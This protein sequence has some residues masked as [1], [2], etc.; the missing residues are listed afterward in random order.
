[1]R[2]RG[3]NIHM[4]RFVLVL[5]ALALVVPQTAVQ[6][7][8][9]RRIRSW[10]E[11]RGSHSAYIDV[12]LEQ[13]VRISCCRS[14]V[15]KKGTRIVFPDIN[16]QTRG[17]FAGFLIERLSDGKFIVGGMRI[18]EMDLAR[19]LHMVVPLT[20]NGGGVL[21]PG[22]YRVRLLT[23][24]QSVVSFRVLGLDANRVYHPTSRST[25]KG[26]LEDLALAPGAPASF[27]R[28]PV[29]IRRG[30]LVMLASQVTA[31]AGQAN[32]LNQ[33][34]AQVMEL[35]QVRGDDDWD[36]K[37]SLGAAESAL[38]ISSLYMPGRVEPGEWQATFTAA[39][40]GVIEEGHT[41]VL[42]VY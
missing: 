32:Y 24:G 1:M 18:P 8:E 16:V 35:C 9:A 3:I 2:K 5:V 25:V 37:P 15:S 22:R 7:R 34:L 27:K 23:D 19:Y 28:T 30:T 33:C 42:A 11:L 41:F 20:P 14:Q 6:G 36:L 21:E 26:S 38:A 29:E 17:T 40:A 31:I 39:S 12:R 10:I 4:R 13:P